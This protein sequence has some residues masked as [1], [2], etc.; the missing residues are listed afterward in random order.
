[1]L[2]FRKTFE[3]YEWFWFHTIVHNIG[4]N[5]VVNIVTNIDVRPMVIPEFF[6]LYC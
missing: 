6:E 1:M 5:V 2:S 4:L 3:L